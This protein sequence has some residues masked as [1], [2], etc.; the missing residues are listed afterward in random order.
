[1]SCISPS[2]SSCTT[3]RDS[4]CQPAFNTCSGL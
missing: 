1:L 3:C 2:S 4:N